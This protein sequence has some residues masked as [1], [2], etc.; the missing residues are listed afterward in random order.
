MGLMDTIVAGLT[1]G[2]GSMM[3]N[4]ISGGLNM[5]GANKQASGTTQVTQEMM[6]LL[7]GAARPTSVT[8]PM[9]GA[10][11]DDIAKMYNINLSP[12]VKGLFNAYMDDT[13]RQRA[14]VE[15]YMTDPEAAAKTR[16]DENMAAIL[17][18]RQSATQNLLSK[19]QTGGLL[20]SSMGAGMVS[21]Q[22]RQN[23]IADAQLMAQS[24]SGVQNTISDYLNRSNSSANQAQNLASSANPYAQAGMNQASSNLAA[25]TAGAPSMLGAQIGGIDAAAQPWYQ[26]GDWVGGL[27]KQPPPRSAYN[28]MLGAP[29]SYDNW[30]GSDIMADPNIYI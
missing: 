23:L 15:K 28:A 6:D 7:R 29:N 3:A 30:K 21:E 22:D 19:L 17:P 16:Y 9:G 8:G 26:L 18:G 1:G 14:L 24:R 27:D 12:Q 20:S 10:H 11:Y 13:Y 2:S 5:A 4:L 25:L